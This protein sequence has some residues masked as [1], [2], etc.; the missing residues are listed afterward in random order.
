MLD[1]ATGEAI[2]YLVSKVDDDE[3]SNKS[4]GGVVEDDDNEDDSNDDD[5]DEDL[6]K[7]A[8]EIANKMDDSSFHS[9]A[10]DNSRMEPISG[11]GTSWMGKVPSYSLWVLAVGSQSSLHT[12]SHSEEV[13]GSS[14]DAFLKEH[15]NGSA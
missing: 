15:A 6:H 4:T 3:N 5:L 2:W 9:G 7:T 11:P 8:T 10:E 14:F 1:I 12:A 13:T